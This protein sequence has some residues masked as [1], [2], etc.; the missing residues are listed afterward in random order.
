M[1]KIGNIGAIKTRDFHTREDWGT[2]DQLSIWFEVAPGDLFDN[3]DF[4][5]SGEDKI[6]GADDD[7]DIEYMYP[8]LTLYQ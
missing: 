2:P 5:F 8:A 3:I 1:D 6:W 4:V 7:T